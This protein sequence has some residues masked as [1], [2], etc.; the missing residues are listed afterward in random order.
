MPAAKK[1]IV[2]WGTGMG[3]K[4]T[5][6]YYKDAFDVVAF[7]DNNKKM[8][9]KSL[10]GRN[11][12]PPEKAIALPFDYVYVASQYSHEIVPQLR[13]MGVDKSKIYT[14]EREIL[15]FGYGR[16]RSTLGAVPVVVCGIGLQEQRAM[17]YYQGKY[18]VLGFLDTGRSANK[19][20]FCDLPV[21]SAKEALEKMPESFWAVA[22]PGA[23]DIFS[24]LQA[25]LVPAHKLETLPAEVTQK[26]ME[27][28][29]WNKK[30]GS[31]EGKK[32]RTVIFGAGDSGIKTLEMLKR[33][34]NVVGFADNDPKKRGKRV[35][36]K[37]VYA[38]KDLKGLKI[39]KIYV[40]SGRHN[41]IFHQLLDMGVEG[42]SLEIVDPY[43]LTEY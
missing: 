25:C 16:D 26:P 3:G 29:W 2:I 6:D 28:A 20:K 17:L 37:P 5:F 34:E 13:K 33:Y 4:R 21:I 14:V 41:Q 7:T 27:P 38:P 30:R 36:G 42:V 11:I 32:K 39:E 43:F 15:I 31:W 9:G 12:L 10:R 35:C 8:H 22:A 24:F 18:K 23:A 40:A 1:S 19:I